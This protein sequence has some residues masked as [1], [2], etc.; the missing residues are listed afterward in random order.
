MGSYT[1]VLNE[2]WLTSARGR[3]MTPAMCSL[4]ALVPEANQFTSQSWKTGCLLCMDSFVQFFIFS[5]S[6]SGRPLSTKHC[7]GLEW[8]WAWIFSFHRTYCERKGQEMS[9]QINNWIHS[10]NSQW[11]PMAPLIKNLPVNAGYARDSGLIPELGRSAGEGNGNLLQYSFFYFFFIFFSEFCL[12]NSMDRGAWW[13][14]VHGV[15]ELD[16]TEC[17]CFAHLHKVNK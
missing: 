1:V 10:E 8:H 12:K 16:T 15:A 2:F 17:T 9:K 7:S 11:F 13:A 5:C 14:I 4:F 6:I 3:I